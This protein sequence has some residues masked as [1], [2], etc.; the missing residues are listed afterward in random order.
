MALS[1]SFLTTGYYSSSKGDTIKLKFSWTATQDISANASTINWQLTGDRTASGYVNAGG[2]KVVIDGETVYSKSTDYRI[3]LRNGTVVASGTKV[4]THNNDGSRTFSAS[5]QGAIYY[6]ED[7]NAKGSASFTLDNIPRRATITAAPNFNDEENPTISYSNLA[8]SA[9]SALT[10]YIT[11][12]ENDSV[13]AF[14]TA[15]IN[16]NSCT[17][18]LTDSERSALRNATLNG[19]DSREVNFTIRTT[20]AGVDYYHSVERTFTVINAKPKIAPVAY[21]TNATAIALTGNRN[22]I[23]KGANKVY[24]EANATAQKGATI[25]GVKISAGDVL[26]ATDSG[27]LE[28]IETANIDINVGDNRGLNT[29]YTYPGLTLVEYAEPT[30]G[31]SGSIEI[32]GETTAKITVDAT[33]VF[34]NINFGAVNNSLTIYYKVKVSS[35]DEYTGDWINSN[36]RFSFDDGRYDATFS[37]DGLDYQKGYTLR[38]MAVDKLKTKYSNEITLKAMPIFDWSGADFNFNVPVKIN[39]VVLDYVV[40]SGNK[41]GWSYRK[42]NSG[43]AECWK[44]LQHNT[45]VNTEWGSLFTGSATNRQDYPF[46][47]SSKP[48]EQVSLTSGSYQGLLFP[49]KDG[50]GENSA[51]N[52]ACYNICRPSAISTSSTFYISFYV[53]GNWR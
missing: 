44:V 42:W 7:I 3:E 32:S 48:V 22:F 38:V 31:I 36:A 24:V 40:E 45:R 21:D 34:S 29:L 12:G 10:C 8:G 33:G 6:Y 39:G 49:E 17:F 1:G 16:G 20:M 37:V 46:N 51:V 50:N 27:Y 26:I 18:N 14:R 2:F 52:S 13:I 35:E 41:S 9:V 25:T 4:I 47:F 43:K 53:V 11:L 5:A 15:A 23:I 19:S 28:N 30:C